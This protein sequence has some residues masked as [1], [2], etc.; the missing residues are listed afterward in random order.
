VHVIWASLRAFAAALTATVH[1]VLPAH[2]GQ[3]VPATAPMPRIEIFGDSVTW[4][5]ES[6]IS[7]ALDHRATVNFHVFGGTSVCRWFDTMRQVA[8]TKPAMVLIT[9]QAWQGQPCDHTSD[10]YRELQDDAGAAADIFR[11]SSVVFASDP[12]A[13]GFQHQSQVDAAY[14]AAAKA[15]SNAEF[16]PAP[17]RV[18][19]PDN[20]FTRTLP[21][22]PDETVAMGCSAS[23]GGVITVRAPDGEH[24][25]P[26]IPHEP[27][28]CPMYASGQRRF[29]NALAGPTIALVPERGH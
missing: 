7:Q 14:R 5:S 3:P 26:V 12:P 24:L 18:V 1:L 29:A 28:H 16:N 20:V 11:D 9:F 17:S 22:L 8:A 4:E 23:S 25:C 21:C 13:K 27:G 10:P 6:Y 19:A 2:H 15:H